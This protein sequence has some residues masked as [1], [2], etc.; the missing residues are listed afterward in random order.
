VYDTQDDL[1]ADVTA[2]VLAM[3]A[4]GYQTQGTEG[5]TSE[6]L[7]NYSVTFAKPGVTATVPGWQ[8]AVSRYRRLV[9]L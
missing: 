8:S 3:A 4:Q 5:I 7:D 9:T 2:A 6:T 1:P